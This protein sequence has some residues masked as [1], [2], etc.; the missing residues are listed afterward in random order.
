MTDIDLLKLDLKVDLILSCSRGEGYEQVG[1]G[2]TRVQ[3][4]RPFTPHIPF[5]SLMERDLDLVIKFVRE[6]GYT[7]RVTHLPYKRSYATYLKGDLDNFQEGNGESSLGVAVCRALVE[8]ADLHGGVIIDKYRN[9]NSV[10]LTYYLE[11]RPLGVSTDIADEVSYGYGILDD[12]G[13][14]QFPLTLKEK[15]EFKYI[16]E[17][18]RL[19]RK[20]V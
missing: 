16:Y 10:G 4:N 19:E 7:L 17:E 15:E 5:Y 13:F 1:D 6:Y 11:G 3:V 20:S 12:L 2:S 18:R 9:V 14:W 8:I